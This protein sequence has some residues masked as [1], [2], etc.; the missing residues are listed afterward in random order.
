[1]LQQ[2]IINKLSSTQLENFINAEAKKLIP[3]KYLS[4]FKQ[5][6]YE[7]LQKLSPPRLAGLGVIEAETILEGD[8]SAI[9]YTRSPHCTDIVI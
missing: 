1:M 3:E 7:D 5:K 8:D 9:L 2:I 6:I 4:Q